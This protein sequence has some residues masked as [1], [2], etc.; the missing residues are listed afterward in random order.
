MTGRASPLNFL[1][2]R[3]PP[4]SYLPVEVLYMVLG[5]LGSMDLL[6]CRR[7]AKSWNQIIIESKLWERIPYPS[8][9]WT[10]LNLYAWEQR[11]HLN[12]INLPSEYLEEMINQLSSRTNPV[13]CLCLEGNNLKNYSIFDIGTILNSSKAL[14]LTRCTMMNFQIKQIF[15]ISP[16]MTNLTKVNLSNIDLTGLDKK[17]IIKA[18]GIKHLTVS[19]DRILISQIEALLESHAE[20]HQEDNWDLLAK[21]IA[22]NGHSVRINKYDLQIKQIF[23]QIPYIGSGIIEGGREFTYNIYKIVCK[24]PNHDP[25]T[26]NRCGIYLK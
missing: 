18:T 24:G 3:V 9:P 26:N 12:N 13:E 25:E 21:C 22:R 4:I 20:H 11:I 6:N 10:R 17:D 19:K 8:N 5:L 7:V 23:Q 16:L 14:S 15:S 2:G 1:P